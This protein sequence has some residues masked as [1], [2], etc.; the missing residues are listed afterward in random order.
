MPSKRSR[1]WK[2]RKKLAA[3]TALLVDS[4][5]RSVGWPISAT[6][7]ET[8]RGQAESVLGMRVRVVELPPDE[9]AEARLDGTF[10]PSLVTFE[11]TLPQP[12]PFVEMT[13]LVSGEDEA[14]T[15]CVNKLEAEP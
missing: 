12:R 4:M 10:D 13:F 9:E 15:V 8:L 14:D 2:R 1:A 3:I 5:R 6:M 11:V 7:L